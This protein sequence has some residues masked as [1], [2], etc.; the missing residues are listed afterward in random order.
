MK[1]LLVAILFFFLQTDLKAQNCNCGDNF[2]FMVQRIQKNYVGYKDKVNPKTQKRFDHLTDSLQKVAR[3]TTSNKCIAVCREWLS[4]FKDGHMNISFNESSPKD[5]IRDFFSKEEKTNWDEEKLKSYLAIHNGQTDSIEG[6]WSN[7]ANTTKL[8]IVQDSLNR[9]EFIGFMVKY[10]TAM[11]A[12][13]QVKFRAKKI[14]GVYTFTSFLARDHSPYPARISLN[15]DTMDLKE[16]GKFYKHD[17]PKNTQQSVLNPKFEKLDDKTCLLTIPSFYLEYKNETD[18]L[19]IKNA[20][21]LENTDH[22][23][24]D[25]RNNRGGAV[26]AFK[27]IFPYLYTNP[28]FT[29]NGQVLAT[30]EN[31]KDGY[32]KPLPSLSEDL[33]VYFKKVVSELKAHRGELYLIYPAE[34]IKYDKIYKKPAR[35][36]I[37]MN[38]GSASASELFI[39]QAKQSTKVKLFGT[40]SSGSVNYVESVTTQMPCNFFNL[41]YPAARLM[42]AN[43]DGSDP[44]IK[45]DVAIPDSVTDWIE[46]VKQYKN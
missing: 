33:Q 34:T 3:N 8:G 30:D 23:I 18:R 36:S 20:S 6:I 21:V 16:I 42:R 41:I 45:P 22:F 10:N 35:V 39:L 5:E 4:F 9:N 37:L 24:I 46:F 14:N 44:G 13:Q 17:L 28:F 1:H 2:S 38:D 25:L 26:G 27:K 40:N 31:I 12:V 29:E 11:W 32:E 43:N 7:L 15:K 19:M